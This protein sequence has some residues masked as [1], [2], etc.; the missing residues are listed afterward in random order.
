MQ[1]K[2]VSKATEDNPQTNTTEEDSI[3]SKA[4]VEQFYY[5]GSILIYHLVVNTSLYKSLHKTI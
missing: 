2:M 5:E 1:I 4:F 3:V